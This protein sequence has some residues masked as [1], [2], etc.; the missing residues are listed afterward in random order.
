MND[1]FIGGG[2]PLLTHKNNYNPVQD[3]ESYEQKLKQS[4][5]QL[6]QKKAALQNPQQHS[7]HQQSQTPVWDEIDVFINGMTDVEVSLLNNDPEYQNAYNR[8]MG[9]LNREQLRIMRPIV[10]N[11]KDG[12]AALEDLF[13]VAKKV[14]KSASD[15]T[16]KNMALF[17]EY[18]SKYADMTYAEF[19]KLKNSGKGGKK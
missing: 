15:E 1:I 12:K 16:A 17:N 6:Q 2:D 8:V 14:R 18:T 11:T 10:E 3:L 9:I 4:L 19:I 7:V 5:E 13:A